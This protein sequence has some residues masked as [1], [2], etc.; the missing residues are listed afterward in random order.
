MS[1]C[2]RKNKKKK[3][4]NIEKKDFNWF[5]DSMKIEHTFTVLLYITLKWNENLILLLHTFW[6]QVNPICF[7]L[8]IMWLLSL[9]TDKYKYI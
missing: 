4:Q 5:L 3:Y 6:I 7:S 8:F 9:H 2:W 1:F